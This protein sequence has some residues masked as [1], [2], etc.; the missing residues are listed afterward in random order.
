M[1]KGIVIT[2]F[3]I[4]FSYKKK[5]TGVHLETLF[6]IFGRGPC[7]QK[8]VGL[9]IFSPLIGWLCKVGNFIWPLERLNDVNQGG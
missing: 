6:P 3:G 9:G 5:S 7:N 4:L 2:F 8:V 1:A